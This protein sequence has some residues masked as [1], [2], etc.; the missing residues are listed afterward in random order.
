MK[1]D[2]QIKKEEQDRYWN[3]CFTCADITSI[4]ED[5]CGAVRCPQFYKRKRAIKDVKAI[6][7]KMK[8]LD[9]GIE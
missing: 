5:R 2:F 4:K 3:K 9:V 7:E 1:R 8:Q 6:E